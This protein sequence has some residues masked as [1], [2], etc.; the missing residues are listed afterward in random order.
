MRP[1]VRGGTGGRVS[2][3]TQPR[4]WGRWRGGDRT[5]DGAGLAAPTS[6]HATPP[7]ASKR[8]PRSGPERFW[9][10]RWVGLI[11]AGSLTTSLLLHY[12]IS[13]WSLFPQRSLE[14]KDTE[15]EITIPIDM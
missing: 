7:D 13:P 3:E 9:S 5:R 10:K 2:P 6:P 12:A 11:A 4:R 1:G 8:R 15:G 14:F